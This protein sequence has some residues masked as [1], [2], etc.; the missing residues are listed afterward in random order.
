MTTLRPGVTEID[1]LAYINEYQNRFDLPRIGRSIWRQSIR[2]LAEVDKAGWQSG[3]T[4]LFDALFIQELAEYIA[5]RR[6]LIQM[7]QWNGLRP[8]SLEDMR[9]LVEVGVYDNEIDHPVFS[10]IP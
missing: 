3:A 6:V 8:Y 1:A 4:W 5:K 2:C 7:G 10:G 9:N